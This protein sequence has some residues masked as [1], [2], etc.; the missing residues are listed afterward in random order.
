MHNSIKAALTGGLLLVAGATGAMAGRG[1]GYVVA[2]AFYGV[3]S[4]L[5]VLS[6]LAA[7]PIGYVVDTPCVRRRIVTD[8]GRIVSRRVC[9]PVRVW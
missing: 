5:G 6:A 2:P 7:P 9:Y 1:G 4:A 8:D 3:P